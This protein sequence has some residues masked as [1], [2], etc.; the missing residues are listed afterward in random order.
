MKRAAFTIIGIFICMSMQPVVAN[1][2]APNDSQTV[3]GN[4]NVL[5]VDGFVTTK[6][7]SVGSEV[8]IQAHTRGHSSSTY[9]SADTVSYT[10]LTLPTK[11]IV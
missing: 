1:S 11:R 9:V 10:H 6:F 4:V 3:S 7:A 2:V 8:D 5:S